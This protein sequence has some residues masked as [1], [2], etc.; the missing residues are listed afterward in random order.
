MKVKTF[1]GKKLAIRT[2]RNAD[3]TRARDFQ[4]FI[5]SLVGE[6]VKILIDKKMTLK[7]EAEFLRKALKG[8]KKRTRVQLVAEHG[9]KI[10]G[11]AHVELGRYKKNHIGNFGI[12][13]IGGYRGLGLGSCLTSELIKLARKELKPRPKIIQ[14]EVY[15]NN[16]PAIGLYKKMGFKTVAR[17]PK[18]IQHKGKLVDALIM[19]K[20]A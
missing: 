1:G 11:V 6:D 4:S 3:L 20:Y 14:L 8:V 9:D 15:A 17:L 13:I 5:N 19:L 12:S 10:V 18:Q 7:D 2:M 16:K